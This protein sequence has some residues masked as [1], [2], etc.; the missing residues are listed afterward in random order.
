MI[1]EKASGEEVDVSTVSAEM[2][3]SGKYKVVQSKGE[4][5]A[6]GRMIFRFKNNFSIFL[7][8]TPNRDA[9]NRPFRAVSHGCI[10]LEKPFELA[11][12]LLDDKA[13][14]VI[15]KMRIALDMPPET[16][17]GMKLAEKRNHPVMGVK[18]FKP[19]IPL[20][21]TYLTAYPDKN[22]N[23]VYTQDPY[24]YDD[25]IMSLLHNY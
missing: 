23:I 21:I 4:G 14:L 5:N 24:G 22:G 1:I 16:E 10:R 19:A 12:F 15:D 7:H 18:S 2:L 3:K 6:L 11:V 9:F 17:E 8:D 20:Y 25:K 13:P